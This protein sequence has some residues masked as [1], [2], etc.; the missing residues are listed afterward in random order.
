MEPFMPQS[1][2]G[3][4]R[5]DDRQVISLLGS[6]VLLTSND[7]SDVATAPAVLAQAP[8]R[9]R[10]LAA[11]KGHDAAWRRTDLRESGITPVIPGRRGRKR[12]IYHDRRRYRER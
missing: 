6:S 5:N 7:A 2:P 3:P 8:G 10:H 9:I 1:Q 12:Q 11:D 4:E